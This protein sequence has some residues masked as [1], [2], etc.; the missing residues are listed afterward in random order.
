ME[1]IKNTSEEVVFSVE[2]NVSLANAIRRSVGEIDILAID[3]CDIYKN[4]SALYDEIIAHRLGLVS[5]KN[6][7][8]KKGDVVEFKLKGKGEVDGKMILAGEM[9]AEVIYPETPIVLLGEGQQLEIVARARAGKG[10]NHAKFMPGLV[11][12]KHLPMIKLNAEGEKQTEL[13]EIYPEVFEMYGEKVKVKNAWKCNLDEEDVKDYPGVEVSFDDN[14]VFAI[15]S[16]GQ[17]EAKK[18]FEES[19]RVLKS[20]LLEVSKA[21]K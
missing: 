3:E 6:Q 2:M 16:W 13:V 7:K 4:D 9:G 14:L 17:M 10:I 12:Y 11:Y 21:V 8:M 5:L 18:I 20:N 15:E 19:C 1:N